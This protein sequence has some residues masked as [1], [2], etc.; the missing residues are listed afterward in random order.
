M[1]RITINIESAIINIG[2][3]ADGQSSNVSVI[4]QK[5][6]AMSQSLEALNATVAEQTAQIAALN[7]TIATEHQQVLDILTS[8]QGTITEQQALI[9]QLQDQIANG[10]TPEEL[11]ELAGRI[12]ANNTAIAEVNTSIATIVEPS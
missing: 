6:E 12:A 7:E 8:Q 3:T 5:V 9:Q 2:G 1:K 11:A 4:L 10:A